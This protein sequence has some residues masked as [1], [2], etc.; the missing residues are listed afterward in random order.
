[1]RNKSFFTDRLLRGPVDLGRK[2]ARGS[3]YKQLGQLNEAFFLDDKVTERM[4]Q[5]LDEQ[6]SRRRRLKVG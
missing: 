4:P 3:Q 6:D 1:M 2:R 5:V